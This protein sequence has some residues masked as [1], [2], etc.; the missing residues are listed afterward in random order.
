MGVAR[1]FAWRALGRDKRHQRGAEQIRP[2]S[3]T[4]YTL[5]E[6]S[7]GALWVGTY[8]G[9]LSRLDQQTG[10]FTHYKHDSGDPN[11]LSNDVVWA[12]LEDS[13]GKGW[14]GTFVVL[15]NLF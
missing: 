3:R 2:P 15:F 12:F 14:S 11:S 5:Y 13:A 4:V 9:G 7:A 10:Q 1:R 6:H 8:Q